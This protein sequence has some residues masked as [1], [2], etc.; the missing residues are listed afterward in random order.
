MADPLRRD[1]PIT[2]DEYLAFEA[3]SA[4]RH[5]YVDGEIY[6]MSGTSRRH[7]KISGNIFARC[8]T[9]ARG[10][11][12]RV[13]QSEVKL[14]TAG[15]FYYP[16]VMVACGAEPQDTYVEDAPCLVV[17]VLSP[18]TESTDRREKLM[19]YRRISSLGAYLIVDQDRRL[20]EHYWRD[21]D[22]WR[23]TTLEDSG[24]V[25][26]PCPAD[27]ALKLDEIYEGVEL[28]PLEEV[29]RVREESDAIYR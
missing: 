25:R 29:L 20:V 5:E 22:G 19:V 15:V 16:D 2:V 18:S 27:F 8:W 24:D 1:R 6:A 9:A 23:H 11:L 17:E 4:V 28:P 21:V 7:S 12:C 13:H 26:L 10:G 3:A 14:R